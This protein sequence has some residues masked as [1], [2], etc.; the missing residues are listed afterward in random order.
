MSLLYLGLA[1]ALEVSLTSREDQRLSPP[2]LTLI[3]DR[4]PFLIFIIFKQSMTFP[5]PPPP[6]LIPSRPSMSGPPFH[7]FRFE[8][9][10][11]FFLSPTLV[12]G[13]AVSCPGLPSL[14]C[15][16]A[17]GPLLPT[18]APSPSDALKARPQTL[19]ARASQMLSSG[20]LTQDQM[21]LAWGLGPSTQGP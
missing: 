6:A 20:S 9:A 18:T 19:L 7:T 11:P 17:P 8:M 5:P 15:T 10:Q 12:A 14:A 21:A 4:F 3:I 1:S 13:M 16:P 2:F